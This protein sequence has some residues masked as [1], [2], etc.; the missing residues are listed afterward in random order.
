MFSLRPKNFYH[1]DMYFVSSSATI[2]IIWGGGGGAG[3]GAGAG[4]G[5]GAGA[6]AGAGGRGE[7]SLF[8]K[9]SLPT[10]SKV[11]VPPYL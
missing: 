6:G 7:N 5:E 9:E 4:A 2:L 8:V 1:F 11:G 3:A 10:R